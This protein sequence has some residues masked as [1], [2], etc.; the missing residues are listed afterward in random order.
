MSAV[1]FLTSEIRGGVA[2]LGL[3]RP[4]KANAYHQPMLLELRHELRRLSGSVHALVLHAGSCRHFCGGADRAELDHRGPQDAF[5]LLSRDVFDELAA[6]PG[7][8]VAAV[9]GAALGGGLELA[10]ACDLRVAANDARFAFPEVGLG[11]I[12]SAGGT[13][14]APAVVGP[15]VARELILFGRELSSAEALTCGLVSQVTAPEAVLDA[16]LAWASRAAG[17]DGLAVALA[18]QSLANP[19]LEGVAQAVLYGRRQAR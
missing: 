9:R 11:L 16:A 4:D 6:W 5:R 12:P 3:H 7:A 2:L 8:T 10:L 13:L 14:R 19:T 1:S 17:R 18:K 15:T